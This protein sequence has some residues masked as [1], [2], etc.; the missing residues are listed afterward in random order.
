MS[1]SH[2]LAALSL[3]IAW[4]A[5]T[6]CRNGGSD[7]ERGLLRSVEGL[8]GHRVVAPR[9]TGEGGTTVGVLEQAAAEKPLDARI[10][11]DLAASYF[12]RAHKKDQPEDLVRALDVFAR[13]HAA[14][15]SLPEARFNLALTLERLYLTRLAQESWKNYLELKEGSFWD[16]EAER[17]LQELSQTSASQQWSSLLPELE[18]ATLRGDENLVLRLVKVSPQAAREFALETS[19]GGWGDAVQAGDQQ[20]AA[21][22]LRIASQV[23]KALRSVSGDETVILSVDAIEKAATDPV[24]VRALATGYREFREGMNAFRPLRTGEAALHFAAA[25]EALAASGSPTE[26][27]ALCGQARCWGYQGR[28]A[29]AI[30]AY[31][32]LLAYSAPRRFFSLTGWTQWGWAWIAARQGFPMEALSRT[33]AM[34]DAYQKAGEAENL[35]AARFLIS[36]SLLLLG[37]RESG[38]RYAYSA[39]EALSTFPTVF[40]RHVLLTAVA[41]DA[42]EEGLAEASL[43]M[44]AEALQVALETRDSIRLTGIYIS[45]ARALSTLQRDDNAFAELAKAERT[46]RGAPQDATGRKLRADLLWTTGEIW[47]RRD[48]RRA[49]VPLSQ[50]IGEYGALK[51]PAALAYTSLAR[52]RAY[53]ALGS[54]RDAKADVENALRI[55]EDP[56]A[57]ITEEDLR[58]SYTDSIDD[59]YDRMIRFQWTADHDIQG[60]LQTL[61]RSRNRFAE[62]GEGLRF[63]RSPKDGVV[64]E[65]AVL[66]D[67][68]L[69][70]VVDRLGCHA[71]ENKIRAAALDLLVERFVRALE[72][73]EDVQN[74]SAQLY[75]LLIPKAV[76]DLP[77]DRVIYFVPDRSLNRV[78]F[79]ALWNRRVSRYLIQDH[80]IAVS[81]SLKQLLRT[82]NHREASNSSIESALLVGNPT[83][84]RSLFQSLGDLPDAEAEVAA[85]QGSFRQSQVLK[86]EQ[87]TKPQILKRLDRYDAFVFAGHA[88]S[89]L[90]RPSQSYLVLAP[91]RELSDPG[92]LLGGEIRSRRFHRLRLVVLSA[93]SSIGPKTARASGLAGIARPFLEAGVPNVVGT[94]WNVRD[95]ESAALLPVF[96][97]AVAGGKPPIHALREM[98]L[99]AS[100]EK[101]ALRVWSSFEIVVR[102]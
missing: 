47:L 96:Y 81:P 59:A 97:H 79:A 69:I 78:P 45:R 86:A 94:L 91:S 93:C 38:W 12:I 51:A 4:I 13:A 99:A 100:S 2:Y 33:R 11:N 40:R 85:A 20:K 49:L 48:P 14:D 9:L 32:S 68:L 102:N 98:Q 10:L 87:G 36:E 72:D 22:R 46:V 29:E 25:Q 67:R 21:R 82:G 16:Q 42:S 17:H 55:L 54:N 101:K 7:P 92:V 24:R 41:T 43:L 89:N 63:D 53:E 52:A 74:L 84:D 76:A 58:L 57:K 28:H 64:V 62:A 26:Q 71:F 83:F 19:L 18:A 39:L 1:R 61:E 5:L 56:A 35:G 3:G 88:V 8:G 31:R 95:R 70:W 6:T 73:A 77:L 37:Q 27:W 44:Q 65:Y 50:A 80:A 15:P 66:Q 90:S 75:D 30:Q 34:E 60:A 23:G